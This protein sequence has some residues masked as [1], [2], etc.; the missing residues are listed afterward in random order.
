MARPFQKLKNDLIYYSARILM[1]FIVRFPYAAISR[2][3]GWFGIL[4]FSLA[5]NERLKTIG[6]LRIAFSGS[7]K[8][9]E[10]VK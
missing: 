8:D 9:D 7:L 3:G 10:I 2:L 6:S 4:V 1:Y 5:R